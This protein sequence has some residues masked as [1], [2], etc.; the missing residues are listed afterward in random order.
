M[1]RSTRSI[2]SRRKLI[3]ARCQEGPAAI[4]GDEVLAEVVA[5]VETKR[6]MA[7]AAEGT[8]AA[9]VA[10]RVSL[11]FEVGVTEVTQMT[12]RQ[13]MTGQSEDKSDR[14]QE[15]ISLVSTTALPPKRSLPKIRQTRS[16]DALARSAPFANRPERETGGELQQRS[17]Q[18]LGSSLHSRFKTK[19]KLPNC[20]PSDKG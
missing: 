6:K 4:G 7:H 15:V 12:A 16:E 10:A 11:A 1:L 19:R 18:T 8:N 20:P 9:R 2:P 3:F 17:D 5:K 14:N 13:L